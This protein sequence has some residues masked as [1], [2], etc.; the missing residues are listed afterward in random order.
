[1]GSICMAISYDEVEGTFNELIQKNFQFSPHTKNI[2]KRSFQQIFEFTILFLKKFRFLNE[3][4]LIAQ[5]ISTFIG[6]ADILL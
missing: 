5:L 2:H 1:M 4:S 3:E 6:N